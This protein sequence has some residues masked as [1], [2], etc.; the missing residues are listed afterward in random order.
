MLP[1][2]IGQPPI[3]VSFTTSRAIVTG[4]NA[5]RNSSI[6]VGIDAGSAISRSRSVGVRPRC[7]KRAERRSDRLPATSCRYMAVRSSLSPL[8]TIC[9]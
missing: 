7:H 9:P 1:A 3:S 5:R 2:L 6:A 4:E 8:A